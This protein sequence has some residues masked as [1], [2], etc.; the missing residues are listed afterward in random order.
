MSGPVDFEDRERDSKILPYTVDQVTLLPGLVVRSAQCDQDVIRS[1]LLDSVREGGQG[2]LVADLGADLG[3]GRERLNVAEDRFEALVRFET[4]LVGVRRKPLESSGQYRGHHE[5][6]G[7]RV[8]QCS[9]QWWKLI[10][11]CDRLAGCD[12][13]TRIFDRGHG[14]IMTPAEPGPR[15]G[16]TNVC[17]VH[18]LF[19][20]RANDEYRT[21]RLMR[22]PLT[23]AAEGTKSPKAAAG[24]NE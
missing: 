9:N 17:L 6:L 10:D 1:E 24:N 21:G 11:R 8:D 12:Q 3:F 20:G 13:Q 23:D 7:R 5:D 18:C 22:D 16:E 19:C 2:C 15:E 4:G 14:R